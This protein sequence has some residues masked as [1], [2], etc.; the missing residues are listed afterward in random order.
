MQKDNKHAD[1]GL[2]TGRR[3]VLKGLTAATGVMLSTPVVGAA[4]PSNVTGNVAEAP[5]ASAT[6]DDRQ[7]FW[8]ARQ[9]GIVNP[10]PATGI[11]ASF[12]AI[13]ETPADLEDLLRRLTARIAFLMTGGTPTELDSK[14]PPSDSGILGPVIKPDNL[15]V[16]VSLGASLFEKRPWLLPF[17]PTALRRMP[18]FTN[19]ALVASLCHGDIALQ[20]CANTQDTNIHALRDILKTLSDRMVL[21][22]KQDGHVP[23][24][25]PRADGRHDSARNFLGFLDGSA[26]PDSSNQT[27][28]DEIVWINP[29]E[30]EP[31]WATHGTYQAVRIIRN[32]VERWDRTPLGEQEKIMGRQ[33]NNGAPLS[34][35][36]HE[37]D[38][39]NFAS[40]AEGKKTPL[41]SHIRLANPRTAASRPNLILRRPFNYSNGATASGQLDQGL[42]FICYQANLERGFIAVQNRLNGEPLE[43]YIKPFGG[44]FFFVLPG[45]PNEDNYL[46]E[47]LLAAVRAQEQK[48]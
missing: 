3:N 32:F 15:T 25:P 33:K 7:P 26:N 18:E 21:K 14:L 20:F 41:D 28:M 5:S 16:T 23:I 29:G 11:I 31:E 6:L 40:D 36:S 1:G 46:G 38:M 10:R 47:Q 4:T 34:G 44:G 43:E 2:R 12:D 24:V 22:W 39:P 45:A 8:G 9:A 19:D 37:S 42:L 35:G 27:A 13:A 30:G 48:K 17:K